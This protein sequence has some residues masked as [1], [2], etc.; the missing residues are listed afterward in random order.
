MADTK[1]ARRGT[2]YLPFTSTITHDVEDMQNRMRRFFG[3]PFARSFREPGFPELTPETLGWNP[4]VEI[5][6]QPAAYMVTVEIPGLT[7]KDV[8]VDFDEGMLTIAGEK[9]EEKEEKEE[10]VDNRKYHLWER[11]Y[12]AFHR[13]FTFPNN[14]NAEK[15]EAKFT[16]GVLTITLPKLAAKRPNAKHIDIATK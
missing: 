2:G 8:K 11:T 1:L 9:K 10:K 13:A 7:A 16:H 12:G 5:V 14:V 3:E 15:I 6:E 4:A